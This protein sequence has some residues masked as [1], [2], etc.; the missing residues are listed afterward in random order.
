MLNF[1]TPASVLVMSPRHHEVATARSNITLASAIRYVVEVMPDEE[2]PRAV[3]Q[4][5]LQSLFI[6]EI[7][8]MYEQPSFPRP[9]GGPV[10]PQ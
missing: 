8:A 2:K 1:E 5:P 3:I 10:R 4:T 6:A 7:E 9:F